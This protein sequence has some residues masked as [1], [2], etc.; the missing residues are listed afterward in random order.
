MRIP[1]CRQPI[2]CLKSFLNFTILSSS[3]GL[4]CY[5]FILAYLGYSP[6]GLANIIYQQAFSNY[7]EANNRYY[8]Y[9][10]SDPYLGN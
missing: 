8:S 3:S 9:N 2:K 4:I 7:D 1:T 6:T 5:F 10:Q